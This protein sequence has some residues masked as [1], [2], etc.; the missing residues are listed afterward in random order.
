MQPEARHVDGF[1]G[2][3][4]TPRAAARPGRRRRCQSGAARQR[5]SAWPRRPGWSQHARACRHGA[6]AV[7]AGAAMSGSGCT[8]D[9][10][11]RPGQSAPCAWM[12]RSACIA[13]SARGAPRGLAAARGDRGGP[14]G[15][16][17]AC[18]SVGS[19][20][21]AG[22]MAGLAAPGRPARLTRLM[23]V[24]SVAIALQCCSHTRDQRQDA[25]CVYSLPQRLPTLAL[26]PALLLESNELRHVHG[27]EPPFPATTCH[28][29]TNA[30]CKPALSKLLNTRLQRRHHGKLYAF[31]GCAH[32]IDGRRVRHASL[33]Y[34][35]LRMVSLR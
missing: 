4:T 9:V 25:H 10:P 35:L 8:W 12:A 23:S 28:K 5:V 16:R 19:S 6:S 20:W 3:A 22:Y 31:H 1:S 27:P 14:G 13:C 21:G 29:Q 34:C 32:G 18:Q 24:S 26:L 33:P 7:Q 17:R 2:L 30:C 11:G 15:Q